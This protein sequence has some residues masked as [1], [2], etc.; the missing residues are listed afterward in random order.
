MNQNPPA[1]SAPAWPRD[2][3][4]LSGVRVTE[5]GDAIALR[6][7]GRL[8]AELGASVAMAS[9]RRTPAQD[10]RTRSVDAYLDQ[11]KHAATPEEIAGSDIVLDSDPSGLGGVELPGVAVRV[12]V[13]PFGSTGPYR[14]YQ[15][16][17]FT[18]STFSGLGRSV[19]SPDHS[20]LVPAGLPASLQAGV[21]AAAGALCALRHR[22]AT[23]Q[24][25]TVDVAVFQT[26][27]T[28]H[29]GGLYTLFE[30]GGP[31]DHRQGRRR[32]APYPFAMFDCRDGQVI[33]DA[34]VGREWKH[35]I[36]AM[37]SPEWASRE[38]Y[39]DR[40]RLGTELYAEADA[41]MAP[42]LMAHT[43]EEIFQVGKEYRIPIAPVRTVP[44]VISSEQLAARKFF[45]PDRHGRIDL[46]L[47]FV[48]TEPFVVTDP[49]AGAPTVET[50]APPTLTS[51]GGS[52]TPGGAALAGVR[53]LDLGRVVA[54]P[55]VGAM[56]ADLG[57]EVIKI[58]SSS[59]LDPGR[60]GR[61]ILP[62]LLD[63]ADRGGHVNLMAVFHN[64]NRGKRS[65]TL[66]LSRPAARDVILRLAESSDV[67]IENF[68]P[69]TMEAFGLGYDELRARNPRIVLV[70]VSG[71]GQNGP[72]RDVL[73]YAGHA[74]AMGGMAGLTGY[75]ADAPL[76]LAGSNFGDANA[77]MYA[78]LGTIA[79]LRRV[80]QSGRGCELDVSMVECAARHLGPEI[81]AYDRENV[82]PGIRGNG[83]DLGFL[84]G[85]YPCA[86]SGDDWIAIS[87]GSADQ[88]RAL[89]QVLDLDQEMPSP[90][91]P[92][93]RSNLREQADARIAERTA[94]RDKIE[95]FHALQAAGV[96]A[97]PALG[98][99]EQVFDPHV[100][101]RD[102]ILAV[103]HPVAGEEW[104]FGFP[105]QL[106]ATPL[107]IRAAAPDLGAHTD[108]VLAE[109]GYGSQEIAGL[110]R[111][112]AV[113]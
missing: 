27:A 103:Q 82:T 102:V 1:P 46:R 34:I 16:T 26:L 11:D 81:I 105:F 104:L 47:P 100:R 87:V 42:W 39:R 97:A 29:A 71:T 56:L 60:M 18:L 52:G 13:S 28:V 93:E 65:L 17:D 86:G 55:L 14:H 72:D 89:G 73:T 62:E 44:E 63:E 22:D 3:A 85:M 25:Q 15:G 6:Y 12:I 2:A 20:P 95:L 19:G 80:H 90:V 7:A 45:I 75:A 67:I 61:P 37:G 78:L 58:E 99:D 70:R 43:R 107:E 77:A 113:E 109:A 38:R 92:G 49:S 48:V 21:S 24:G 98:V 41:L 32:L 91:S 68:R 84:Q 31:A 94:A 8:L 96:P 108:E 40:R 33:I 30:F 4:P 9:A 112:G 88:W 35:L 66:D 57:A 23:G 76:G 101:A 54:A 111:D 5:A 51:P 64:V 79:A 36:E 69:G 83:D 10:S 106:S 110:R 74:V 50:G 53:V 59:H